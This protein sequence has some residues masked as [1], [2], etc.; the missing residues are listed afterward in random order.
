MDPNVHKVAQY[1]VDKL[2]DLSV[3]STP[4]DSQEQDGY[5]DDRVT[6][7]E[8][9]AEGS[10]ANESDGEVGPESEADSEIQSEQDDEAGSE[11]EG[12]RSATPFLSEDE[13]TCTGGNANPNC[14]IHGD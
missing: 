5:G 4:K 1:V 2:T 7:Q 11:N 6:Q 12:A 3:Q 10:E 9:W 8:V 13:C 14:D